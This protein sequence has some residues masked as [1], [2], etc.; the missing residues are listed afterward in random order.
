MAR[1]GTKT[2]RSQRRRERS[3][4]DPAR[5]L[6]KARRL[7]WDLAELVGVQVVAELS[8]RQRRRLIRQLQTL[9]GFFRYNSAVPI[10]PHCPG[11]GELTLRFCTAASVVWGRRIA[12]STF[13]RW[14]SKLKHGGAATLIDGRGRYEHKGAR[15]DAEL[16]LELGRAVRRGESIAAAHR[17]LATRARTEGRSWPGLGTTQRRFRQQES[18]VYTL[19]QKHKR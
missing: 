6:R 5:F 14:L 4:P 19:C 13:A 8:D 3:F 1:T 16:W 7:T 10:R 11:H 15:P 18:Y 9:D 17:R 12:V 2:R